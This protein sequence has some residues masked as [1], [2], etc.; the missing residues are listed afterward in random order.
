[1]IAAHKISWVL[2]VRLDLIQ[3][4]APRS[5]SHVTNFPLNEMNV[6]DLSRTRIL[7]RPLTPSSV[8]KSLRKHHNHTLSF[9][10]YS[11]STTI[12]QL[13]YPVL[14]RAVWAYSTSFGT[15]P[16]LGLGRISASASFGRPKLSVSGPPPARVRRC[17][18]TLNRLCNLAHAMNITNL[19]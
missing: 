1:M 7:V 6:P 8:F 17:F 18:T 11:T 14:R 2:G 16:L 9:P 4:R 15:T 12:V 19:T 10:I 13:I 3:L 5:T